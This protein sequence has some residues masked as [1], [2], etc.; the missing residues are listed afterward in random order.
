MEFVWI[1][2]TPGLRIGP[3][4]VRIHGPLHL[5]RVPTAQANRHTALPLTVLTVVV[6]CP[7]GKCPHPRGDISQGDL[8]CGCG[9]LGVTLFAPFTIV[10]S[11]LDI[12][13]NII[14]RGALQ[15]CRRVG[16]DALSSV[17]AKDQPATLAAA[18]R[19]C[20]TLH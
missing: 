4:D 1:L 18:A 9:G 13:F 16:G 12:V 15:Q 7:S 17:T 19:A 10:S 8:L 20:I 3:C 5:I 11:R 2:P 14:V 6:S